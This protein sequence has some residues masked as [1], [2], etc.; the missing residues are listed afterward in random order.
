MYLDSATTV[1]GLKYDFMDHFHEHWLDMTHLSIVSFRDSS[2]TGLPSILKPVIDGAV[3]NCR[4]ADVRFVRL[5]L[6]LDFCP[7][8][9]A[10]AATDNTT[11][12]TNYY[13]ELPQTT[14]AVNDGH[15]HPRNLI[16]FHGTADLRTLSVQQVEDAILQHVPQGGPVT[17]REAEDF[18]TEATI[19]DISPMENITRAILKLAV[20]TVERAIFETLCPNYPTKPH[21]AVEGLSQV[22]VGQDGN[23]MII[24]VAQFH[25]ILNHA[26][27]PFAHMKTFPTCICTIFMRG[28]HD[29]VKSVFQDKYPQYIDPIPLDGRTQRTTLA[30]LLLIATAAE[31]SVLSTQRLVARQ[32]GTAFTADSYASQA[33]KT[34]AR[35]NSPS[36]PASHP[37][38]PPSS[39]VVRDLLPGQTCHGF[40]SSE[41]P[42]SICPRKNE[43][44]IK[45][46]AKKNF[47]K[48]RA[49]RREE[50]RGGGSSKRSRWASQQPNLN[51][52]SPSVRK[53]IVRQVLES[54]AKD[55]DDS[56]NSINSSV[57][58]AS[59]FSPRNT[60]GHGNSHPRP[61]GG[62]QSSYQGAI[63]IGQAVSFAT[64][65]KEVLPVPIQ[66]MLPHILLE[67]VG[68][69]SIWVCVDT[70]ASLCTGNSSFLFSIAKAYPD[71]VAAVY[72][73][74]D[75]SEILLS[76]IVR[77]NNEV[78]TT[79]LP[80]AF[81]F[82]LDY[83]TQDGRNAQLM[84]AAGP[85]VSVN[86]I[87]GNPF[88]QGA[89]AVLNFADSVAELR[90]F[91]CP[92]F[93]IE[94]RRARL[95]V[96]TPPAAPSVT[97]QLSQAQRVKIQDFECIETLLTGASVGSDKRKR[98]VK[99]TAP[100]HRDSEVA[101]SVYDG[102]S[103]Y[104]GHS[105]LLGD[106]VEL[107]GEGRNC[108]S[109]ECE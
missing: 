8:C 51:D 90:A 98:K 80:I 104:S 63:F 103:H 100:I 41:H 75:Y 47:D 22:T 6:S 20:K 46:Q 87:V 39:G 68:G 106:S 99:W 14:I 94:F 71:S 17:L 55:A 88:F 67:L 33:E 23:T 79:S 84:V 15:G 92:P 62:G 73:S 40:G 12:R 2:G 34:L 83:F 13:L 11:V 30:K 29:D 93:P 27:Q 102:A 64:D 57:T 43:P 78:V 50:M 95:T 52:M 1:A 36:K 65:R 3:A 32:V 69:V 35:Y 25:S 24:P 54:E 72:T 28:L 108:S 21:A 37:T 66:S 4:P 44:A 85:D 60:A 74:Q 53:K 96:Q 45:A 89:N 101:T 26:S 42:Y 81:L 97:A 16:T 86:L 49:S 56:T 5:E 31:N 58:G 10:A 9:T 59:A 19:D 18:V 70:A 7:L 61:S 48:L 38:K 107:A 76:G 82:N 77:R 109:A 91:D 105:E